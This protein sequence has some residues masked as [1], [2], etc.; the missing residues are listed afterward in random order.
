MRRHRRRHGAHGVEP[1]Q[2]FDRESL[3][4]LFGHDGAEAL[5][6]LG[7]AR[8][9]QIAAPPVMRGRIQHLMQRAP[10]IDRRTRE[11]QLRRIAA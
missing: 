7:R 8:Q 2:Q 9:T 10:D 5:D 4:R 3:G 11:R 6:L 1:F